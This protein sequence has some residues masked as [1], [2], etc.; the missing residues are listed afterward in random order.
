MTAECIQRQPSRDVLLWASA[1][2]A[3]Q[4]F[5]TLSIL[6]KDSMVL[7]DIRKRTTQCNLARAYLNIVLSEKD[8]GETI[9]APYVEQRGRGRRGRDSPQR[10][11]PACR[12]SVSTMGILTTALYF[13]ARN[14]G[15]A[16][17]PV[18]DNFF[19]ETTEV[20]REDRF[21]DRKN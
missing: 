19:V 18:V 15:S 10:Q 4:L 12:N 3:Q 8:L 13:V 6:Y 21:A 5:R 14:L 7:N 2:F 1:R 9:G 17:E 11:E 20:E 16:M